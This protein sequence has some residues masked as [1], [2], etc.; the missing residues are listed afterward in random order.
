MTMSDPEVFGY[1]SA[2]E[3]RALDARRF[4]GLPDE[5]RHQATGIISYWLF[6]IA[7]DDQY[8]ARPMIDMCE[9]W[10]PG[11][12]FKVSDGIVARYDGDG[13]DQVGLEDLICVDCPFKE[14]IGRTTLDVLGRWYPYR[15]NE[16]Q[17]RS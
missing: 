11:Y 5:Q 16:R 15:Q 13:P 14:D 17:A 9:L 10:L 12:H 8:P 7:W 4:Q 2:V 1:H 3:H 6:T